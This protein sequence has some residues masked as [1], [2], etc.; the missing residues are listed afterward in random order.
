[1]V[2]SNGLAY[3]SQNLMFQCDVSF[4]AGDKI[5]FS[6]SESVLS[7]TNKQLKT[8]LQ[9]EPGIYRVCAYL[10]SPGDSI[11]LN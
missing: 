8:T 4:K 1:M 2:D 9:I 3:N 7:I 11:Y 10:L 5:D 6:Y